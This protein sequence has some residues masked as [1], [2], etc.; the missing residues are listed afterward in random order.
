VRTIFLGFGAYVGRIAS[1]TRCEL[2]TEDPTEHGFAADALIAVDLGKCTTAAMNGRIDWAE[3]EVDDH[4]NVGGLTGIGPLWPEGATLGAVYLADHFVKRLA[5]RPTLPVIDGEPYELKTVVYHPGTADPRAGRRYCG[6]HAKVLDRRGSHALVQIYPGG[7]SKS[8][9]P[10]A[11]RWIDLRSVEVCDVGASSMTAIGAQD[12]G[13]LFLEWELAT[14]WRVSS[15]TAFDGPKLPIGEGEG[16]GPEHDV[17]DS[18]LAGVV[19]GAASSAALDVIG[20]LPP[21]EGE[22]GPGRAE[23]GR[24]EFGKLPPSL[25]GATR[26]W[27]EYFD[28]PKLP[29]SLGEC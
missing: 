11:A 26:A 1:Q 29:V 25:G 15:R 6:F 28:I 8:L 7:S 4:V 27:P 3:V 18:L 10:L 5:V 22:G 21:S 16:V 13:A 12:E 2:W 19:G 23:P 24:D 9:P 20:K 14:T 17:T